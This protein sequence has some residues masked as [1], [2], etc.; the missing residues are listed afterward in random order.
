MAQL[1]DSALAVLGAIIELADGD[2]PGPRSEQVLLYARDIF[3]C[4]GDPSAALAELR[5][6]ELAVT[7]SDEYQ[8]SVVLRPGSSE[9]VIYAYGKIGLRLGRIPFPG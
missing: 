6:S 5:D 3:R 9:A 1:S 4:G 7:P 8:T 2:G